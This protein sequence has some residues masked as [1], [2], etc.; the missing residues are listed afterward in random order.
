MPLT[1][2]IKTKSHMSEPVE[3][4]KGPYQGTVQLPLDRDWALGFSDGL[5][6]RA[7]WGCMVQGLGFQGLG[8]RV[9]G[10]GFGV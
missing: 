9:W 7:Q 2:P 4:G 8:F 1:Y 6:L 5:G 10:L 3:G